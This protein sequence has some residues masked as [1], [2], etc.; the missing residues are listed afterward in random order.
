MCQVP[1]IARQLFPSI[2]LCSTGMTLV[3]EN[4]VHT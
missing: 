3:P 2:E 1:G 4:T